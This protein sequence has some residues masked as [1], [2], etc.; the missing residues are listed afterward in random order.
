[1]HKRLEP[2][3]SRIELMHCE[4]SATIQSNLELRTELEDQKAALIP[5]FWN[6]YLFELSF[7]VV[8]ACS[9]LRDTFQVFQIT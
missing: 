4:R 5:L 2:V 7:P 9:L 8:L 1:M 6:A 3:N